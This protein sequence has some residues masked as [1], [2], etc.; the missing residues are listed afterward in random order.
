MNK[1]FTI[2]GSSGTGKTTIARE[3]ADKDTTIVSYTTREKREGEVEGLDYYYVTKEEILKLK[4]EGKLVE[5]INFNDNYYGYS[6]E[7]FNNKLKNGNCVCVITY[8]GLEAILKVDELK[9]KIVPI[10]LFAEK[11]KIIDNLLKR[12]GV[13]E[14]NKR[15]SLYETENENNLNLYN[16]LKDEMKVYCINTTYKDKEQ[17]IN[18]VKQIIE[19]NQ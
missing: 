2:T 5:F 12:G 10:F 19:E 15:L 16:K 4:D 13:S 9:D 11:E 18:C 8:D 6:Y 3:I 14:V 1:I 17:L 7:E